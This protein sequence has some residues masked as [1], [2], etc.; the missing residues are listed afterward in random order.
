MISKRR[1]VSYKT[2]I[3]FQN[4]ILPEFRLSRNSH[5]PGQTGECVDYQAQDGQEKEEPHLEENII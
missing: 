1:Q 4:H 3:F 5:D 2:L